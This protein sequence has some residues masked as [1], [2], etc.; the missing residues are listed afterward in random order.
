MDQEQDAENAGWAGDA[1]EWNGHPLK[2]C[3]GAADDECECLAVG[4]A[5]CC[6][7]CVGD[8]W[9]AGFEEFCRE[10]DEGW[11]MFGLD[12]GACGGGWLGESRPLRDGEE[13]WQGFVPLEG[14][15][16]YDFQVELLEFVC[17]CGAVVG[18][19][20]RTRRED[21]HAPEGSGAQTVGGA[22]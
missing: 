16:R 1:E 17:D 2:G 18:S 3:W 9:M 4:Q 22:P 21:A 5:G 14:E 6:A 12:C 15:V 11:K 13:W 20:G 8:R 19:Q 7:M 10:R